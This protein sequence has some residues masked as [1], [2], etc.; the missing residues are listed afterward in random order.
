MGDVQF[1][2]HTEDLPHGMF[3]C[4]EAGFRL[5]NVYL[6]DEQLHQF[7]ESLQKVNSIQ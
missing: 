3:T 4:L 5:S 1:I 2:E 6:W 7:W